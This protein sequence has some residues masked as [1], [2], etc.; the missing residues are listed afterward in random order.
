[1]ST[2]KFILTE[3][4]IPTAWYNIVADMKNKPL[5][6]IDPKTKQPV[7][8]EGM[9][10]LFA[11]ELIKQELNTTDAW[12][13]IPE[14]V[15]DLYKIWRPT[16]LVR[17]TGLEKALDTPAHIYFKNESVSP[18]G[19]HKLNS[20][21]AQAY[22]CKEEGCTNITTETGAGQWGAALSMASKI[23]GLELAV[24]MVKVSYHQKPYRR[25][26]MQTFGAQVIASPSMSTKAGRK[27]LTDTPN[28]QGSL[29]CAISEAVELAMQTPNCKYV[30]GSVF[31]WVSLHQTVIGLE[32]EKQMEM[33][34]EYPD[35]V[36]ACFGGGSNFSGIAF[37]FLRHKLTNGKEVEIIA[38]E[39]ASCPK[40]SKGR[41]Q[42]DFG[43][44]AGYTPLIPMYTLGHN[45]M[46]SNIHAG[47]L[48]Y[49]GAGSIVSQLQKDGYMRAEDVNQLEAF[50]A[51]TLF[52]K[53]EGIIPAPESSHA[54]AVA[55]R[56]ALKA[57][58]EGRKEVILFNL[59]GHGLIDM[60]A[61]D[62]YIAGDLVNGEVT[63]EEITRNLKDVEDFRI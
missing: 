11:K 51:A 22:Y 21:L 42:Y 59:S 36:I 47:G 37:P 34:G 58:E 27:I 56:K 46:P 7:T 50:D 25:S 57:K 41:F 23:F 2:K 44:E 1:M 39:P 29:G 20:A 43:D 13:E 17:A 18:V 4:D 14:P 5:P 32:A 10:P 38:A 45:F 63:D 62:R 3:Q 61:Y 35:S 54:I 26:I 49:H 52:A 12:I 40:L 24:Y 33:A 6:M 19:S 28:N 48:R 60:A 30:L 55:I 15:R 16:P 31:N 53:S 8:A 9:E